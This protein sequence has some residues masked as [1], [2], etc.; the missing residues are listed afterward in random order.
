M[1]I[2]SVLILFFFFTNL[3]STQRQNSANY[4]NLSSVHPL[5]A[6]CAFLFLVFN[7]FSV[8]VLWH[9][10]NQLLKCNKSYNK[11]EIKKHNQ[12]NYQVSFNDINPCRFVG[13]QNYM[14]SSK[15]MNSFSFYFASF[16]CSTIFKAK[17]WRFCNL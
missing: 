1:Q 13:N 4:L 2:M 8:S 15:V 5:C 12:L 6:L 10:L 17:K 3:K 16:W 14:R 9:F 11:K 7:F